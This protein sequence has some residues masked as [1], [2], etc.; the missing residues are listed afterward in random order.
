MQATAR[1]HQ[2]RRSPRKQHQRQQP[3]SSS[4]NGGQ[5]GAGVSEG[6]PQVAPRNGSNQVRLQFTLK[7]QAQSSRANTWWSERKAS[8]RTLDHR[9]TTPVVSYSVPHVYI[10]MM[11]VCGCP[12]DDASHVEGSTRT[13]IETEV[14][15]RMQAEGYQPAVTTSHMSSALIYWQRHWPRSWQ[16]WEPRKHQ[17]ARCYRPPT[18]ND[19]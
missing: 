2:Q 14:D 8:L 19:Q 5:P 10:V 15:E 12:G 3:V 13:V 16:Q 7:L 4:A 9:P 18:L 1:R 17:N 6:L 11:V